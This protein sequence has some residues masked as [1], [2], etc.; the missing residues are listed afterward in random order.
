MRTASVRAQ[1]KVKTL[2]LHKSDYD[3]FVKDIQQ[4]ERRENFHI[5][6]R[7]ALFQGW[8]RAKVE[9]MAN[10]ATRREFPA[11]T[12]IFKQGDMPD[13]VYVVIDGQIE[14][15]KEVK[16]TSR[17]RWPESM[18][19]WG[20]K[21]R[22]TMKQIIVDKVKK[23]GFF[24]ELSILKNKGR[25]ASA[26]TTE[27]TQ[28]LQLGKLEFLHLLAADDSLNGQ[29]MLPDQQLQYKTDEELLGLFRH[30]AGGPSSTIEAYT[31]KQ[32][33]AD[34]EKREGQK[35]KSNLAR[36]RN[37][38]KAAAAAAGEAMGSRPSPPSS[39]GGGGRE[40]LPAIGDDSL[41]SPSVVSYGTHKTGDT[42]NTAFLNRMKEELYAD[43]KYG[44]LD[45]DVK[46]QAIITVDMLS[47]MEAENVAME[48]EIA[49][50][51]LHTRDLKHKESKASMLSP[52]GRRVSAETIVKL[53]EV[54]YHNEHPSHH[55]HSAYDAPPSHK[56]SAETLQHRLDA[57]AN[58]NSRKT[59]HQGI[60]TTE[61][62]IRQPGHHG[63]KMW[64]V[65]KSKARLHSIARGKSMS[66]FEQNLHD[67]K[68]HSKSTSFRRAES[69]TKLGTHGESLTSGFNL[70][71]SIE[72]H[73]LDAHSSFVD[74]DKDGNNDADSCENGADSSGRRERSTTAHTFLHKM[75]HHL[76][77]SQEASKRPVAAAQFSRI[78]V[79]TKAR[80]AFVM[81]LEEGV[82]ATGG[83]LGELL[84]EREAALEVNK[85]VQVTGVP[86]VCPEWVHD[87][88]D[89]LEGLHIKNLSAEQLAEFYDN[90][91]YG[92]SRHEDMVEN[93]DF[94]LEHMRDGDTYD[95]EK[96][97]L[98]RYWH[99][100]TTSLFLSDHTDTDTNAH[101]R[102][103]HTGMSTLHPLADTHRS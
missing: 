15:V 80:V 77:L 25:H 35:K 101:A 78:A 66:R 60:E 42:T 17:N 100:H 79:E 49:F 41:D 50:K 14:I 40:H 32:S 3:L 21:A 103:C 90:Y 4:V 53:R 51:A 95:Q 26:S 92:H 68:D 81:K 29:E 30:V 33:N 27:Y 13:Y 86:H 61:S 23:D 76:E 22:M 37:E 56:P 57:H 18:D 62:E 99:T 5:F 46:H 94:D 55:Q 45:V 8:P 6:R 74:V 91:E 9:K 2:S 65:P 10:T 12:D 16:I 38:S 34:I 71:L 85:V 39:P 72:Q 48:R 58:R 67:L 89:D 83:K 70:L 97:K 36:L 84:A 7:C 102:H 20:G 63:H 47:A 73:H 44:L 64:L 1:T 82:A 54:L 75:E 69:M 59:A 24:G 98:R 96:L 52:H 11:G 31:A 93:L 43:E 87:N 19:S 88:D 28:L